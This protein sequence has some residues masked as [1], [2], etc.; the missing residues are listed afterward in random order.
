[1]GFSEFIHP[2]VYR[3]SVYCNQALF[4]HVAA[5]LNINVSSCLLNQG[6]NFLVSSRATVSKPETVSLLCVL[7]AGN[8]ESPVLCK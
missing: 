1:M 4:N 5:T 2:L 7:A 6:E 8:I 3:W